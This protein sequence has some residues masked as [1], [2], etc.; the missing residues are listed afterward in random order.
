M[1]QQY[2][3]RDT[4]DGIAIWN[5][6]LLIKAIEGQP[7]REIPLAQL[8]EI[9]QP[10]WYAHEGDTPTVRSITEHMRLV[11]A[12]DLAYPIILCAQGK[13]MDGMHR[14]AKALLLGH[15]H[16]QARQFVHTPA[17]DYMNIPASELSYDD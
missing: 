13:V 3:F 14:V 1:R 5:V 17:P 4:P 7:I 10:Y 15:R 8:Q 16:I 2:H 12:A 9:D 11:E 6:N